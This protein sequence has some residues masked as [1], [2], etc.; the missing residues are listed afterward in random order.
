[1]KTIYEEY[2][3]MM[4]DHTEAI[5]HCPKGWDTLVRDLIVKIRFNCSYYNCPYPK[6]DQIKEKFG[7]LRFYITFTEGMPDHVCST[8]YQYISDAEEES[9]KLCEVTGTPGVFCE[10]NHWVKV[11]CEEQA[12]ILGYTVIPPRQK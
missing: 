8:I 3:D 4:M 1:M 12:K 11:L 5:S 2:A 6:I 10:K 7:C 9:S